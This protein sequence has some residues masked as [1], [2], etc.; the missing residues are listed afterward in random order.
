MIA[1]LSSRLQS[2]PAALDRFYRSFGLDAKKFVPKP[3]RWSIAKKFPDTPVKMLKD[4]FKA[5]KLYDLVELLEKATK[6]R[7]LQPAFSIKEMENLQDTRDRPPKFYGKAEALIIQDGED[8]AVVNNS[9]K[10]GTFFK[11]LNPETQVSTLR[12]EPHKGLLGKLK[13]VRES[14]KLTLSHGS[15]VYGKEIKEEIKE[16]FGAIM[17]HL[18]EE[19]EELTKINEKFVMAVSTALDKWVEHANDEGWLTFSFNTTTFMYIWC[20]TVFLI[21]VCTPFQTCEVISSLRK[22]RPLVSPENNI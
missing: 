14:R 15:T 19:G 5:L 10:I 1:D 6:P 16:E 8:V 12:M 3:G 7:L 18:K 2:D 13:Q 22:Q 4:A 9:E 11:A 21:L 20:L 17:T